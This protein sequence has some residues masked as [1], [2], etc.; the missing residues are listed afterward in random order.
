VD[1]YTQNGNTVLQMM[2]TADSALSS[3][4]SEVNQAISVGVEGANG[5]LSSSDRAALAQQVSGTLTNVVS[6][7][8]LSYA[9][10][11]VFAGTASTATPFTANPS[12][13]SGYQYNG[14]SNV[15]SVAI[16]DGVEVPSNVP[17][18][19]LFQNPGADLLGSLQ[20]LVSAL[21]SGTTSAIGTATTQLRAA[22]DNLSQRRVFYGNVM[23]QINS[24]ETFLQSETVNI[25]S[26]EDSLVAVDMTTAAT[27]FTQ[28]QAA[29]QATMAAAAR[30]LQET[31]LDYLR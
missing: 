31:L 8:N 14:N 5:T 12:S 25:K 26:Q 7:A 13:P 2:Q 3:V 28:A 20:Q 10:I 18:D 17:G 15:N 23:A 24:Q 19:Q 16:G 30:V 11:Y 21:Q 4:V 6:Q 22:L 1:Q 29:S 9:G 27:N